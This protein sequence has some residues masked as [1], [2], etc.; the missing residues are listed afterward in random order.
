M[1]VARALLSDTK[2]NADNIPRNEN[3]MFKTRMTPDGKQQEKGHIATVRVLGE[4]PGKRLY[5]WTT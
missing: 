2:N 5:L 3:K 1:C 4:D